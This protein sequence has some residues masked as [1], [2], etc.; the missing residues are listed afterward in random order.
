MTVTLHNLSREVP[1]L[2]GL[3]ADARWIDSTYGTWLVE[4]ASGPGLRDMRAK[5]LD[6]AVM[7]DKEPDSVRALCV[8]TSEKVTMERLAA[9]LHL[10]R[11]VF[12]PAVAARVHV[13]RCTRSG[14]AVLL[15]PGVPLV[16]ADVVSNIVQRQALER[17]RSPGGTRIDVL[18]LL[19]RAWIDHRPPL[20][21]KEVQEAV[22]ASHPTVAGVIEHLAKQGVLE[23]RS[24]RRVMLSRF[25]I[26]E[27]PHWLVTNIKARKIA[28]FVDP[29][30]QAR[31]PYEMAHRLT[32]VTKKRVAVSGAVGAMKHYPD[33]NITSAP[34][35]DL[36]VAGTQ[37][38]SWVAKLDAGLVRDDDARFPALAVHI[39]PPLADS[40]FTEIDG[41]LW[42]DPLE[43]LVTMYEA[44]LN[45]QCEDMLQYLIRQRI[46]GEA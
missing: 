7:L 21:V 19:I 11:H 40:T 15:E 42:A 30:R 29:S 31:S 22:G 34:R 46:S 38:L 27:W 36:S 16:L 18:G 13:G 41:Q 24:D 33:L 12:R 17:R 4:L 45:D 20:M 8:I 9:D 14:D 5:L 39:L 1:T 35:L 26:D 43:C 28:R 44:K 2:S 25:P 10:V 32:K 23:R 6:A 3:R 37:D